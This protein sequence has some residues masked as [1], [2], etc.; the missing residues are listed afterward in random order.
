MSVQC[1]EGE[2]GSHIAHLGGEAAC[3]VEMKATV[4]MMAAN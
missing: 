4:R 1:V 2:I 3:A